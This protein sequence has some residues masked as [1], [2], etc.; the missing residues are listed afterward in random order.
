MLSAIIAAGCFSV[1]NQ[2]CIYDF[3]KC[4]GLNFLRKI[5]NG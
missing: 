3:V 1:L 5:G 4:L 2:K